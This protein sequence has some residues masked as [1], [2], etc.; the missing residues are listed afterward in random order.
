M[1]ALDIDLDDKPS[2]AWSRALRPDGITNPEHG[3][4]TRIGLLENG[5]TQGRHTVSMA[6]TL[7]SGLIVFAEQTW[8]NF[9][10]A[11]ATLIAKWGTP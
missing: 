8:K 1:I 10:I 4:L 5:T 7:D 2:Y 11:A 3:I 6:I 9:S